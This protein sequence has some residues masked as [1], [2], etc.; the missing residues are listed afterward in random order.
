[1]E[2]Q[3]KSNFDW[4]ITNRKLVIFIPNYGRKEYV[5]FGIKNLITSVPRDDW[6]IIIGNDNIEENFDN[7]FDQNVRYFTLFTGNS[8]PR[9]SC[10][11]RNY[12]IKRCMSNIFFQKDPEVVVIGD[13]I[14]K[15]IEHGKGWRT[16]FSIIASV[17]LSRLIL[18]NGIQEV[19]KFLFKG[20]MDPNICAWRPTGL[21]AEKLNDGTYRGIADPKHLY[22]PKFIKDVI[23]NA[24]G[25]WNESTCFAYALGIETNILKEIGGYDEDYTSYGYEDSDLF[26]RLMNIKYGLTPD[27]N[28]VSV[29]LHHQ[30]TVDGNLGKMAQMFNSKD[31]R[32]VIRNKNCWGEGV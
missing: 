27:Y 12:A 28:C 8:K 22:D 9:N 15:S 24:N 13:F 11:I 5:E 32:E 26:C 20:P 29:H 7:L 10:K 3:V 30:L 31:Y 25:K 19:N 16:G 14:K 1:M 17:A 2:V 18:K 23:F 21:I 4:S 6:V